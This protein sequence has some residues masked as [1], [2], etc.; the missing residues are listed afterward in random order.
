M[1]WERLTCCKWLHV[2]NQTR[3]AM[4][5]AGVR[6]HFAAGVSALGREGCFIHDISEHICV[7]ATL[8]PTTDVAWRCGSR[9]GL[10]ASSRPRVSARYIETVAIL[11]CMLRAAH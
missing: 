1:D 8:R 2:Q 5:S 4:L 3:I 7:H 11:P 6:F 10:I 9:A